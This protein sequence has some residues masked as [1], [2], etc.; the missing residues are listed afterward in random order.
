MAFVHV[1][2]CSFL[3]ITVNSMVLFSCRLVGCTSAERASASV[4]LVWEIS[5]ERPFS[6]RACR[7]GKLGSL[8]I[9]TGRFP[10]VGLPVPPLPTAPRSPLDWKDNA[11]FSPSIN[12]PLFPPLSVVPEPCNWLNF[13]MHSSMSAG[14]A[15]LSA[16]LTRPQNRTSNFLAK[17]VGDTA[18]VG[19]TEVVIVE[20]DDKHASEGSP[21]PEEVLLEMVVSLLRAELLPA[22]LNVLM[23]SGTWRDS[24][25]EIMRECTH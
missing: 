16:T 7:Q 2:V 18:A 14:G 6:S 11:L 5:G 24:E 13:S 1:C 8:L 25:Q 12:P 15:F 21:P 22:C 10:V 17:A 4:V 19:A 23:I 3:K 20:R 9:K